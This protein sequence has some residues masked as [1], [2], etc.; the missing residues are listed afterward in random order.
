M[1]NW[2]TKNGFEIIRVLSG[3]SNAYLISY[4]NTF[5][6]VDTGKKEA[7]KTLL[8]NIESF[9]I[10]VEDIRFLVLTHTH[11]DHCQSARRIKEISDCQIIVSAL[12]ENSIKNGYAPLPDG[13]YLVTK[14]IARLGRFIGKRKFGFEPFHPDIF[15][16]GA[17]DLKKSDR[18]IRI[19]ETKGHS[20]DSVSILVDSEIAIVGDALFG[21]FHNSVF[22]PYSDD[23]AKMLESWGKLLNTDCKVFL[24]GH[25]KE[26]E[27]SLL[28]KEYSRNAQKY[29]RQLREMGYEPV[30]L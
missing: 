14:L 5:I 4:D 18:G 29:K 30:N 17:F 21:V 26:I 27:R 28:E 12:A 15:V 1:R 2:K 6:L 7:F 25:G 20:V 8:K 22:P 24:P 19:I 9:N 10:T 23:I 13:T 16:D 11:F 3:R